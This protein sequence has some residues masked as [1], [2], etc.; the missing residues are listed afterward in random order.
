MHSYFIFASIS[1]EVQK[2][3][4]LLKKKIII[5]KETLVIFLK[6]KKKSPSPYIRL[7]IAKSPKKGGS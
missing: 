6:L 2:K 3:V 1:L 4:R 5:I 7:N